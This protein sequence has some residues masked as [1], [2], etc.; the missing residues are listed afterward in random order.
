[1]ENKTRM[2]S[3]RDRRSTLF[4]SRA[5]RRT[6]R[7]GAQPGVTRIRLRKYPEPS[8]VSD[9]DSDDSLEVDVR[10]LKNDVP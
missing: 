4:T 7:P 8:T 6:H 9:I 3:F 1:M 5:T 10:K 2:G